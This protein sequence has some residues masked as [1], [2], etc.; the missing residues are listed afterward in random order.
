LTLTLPEGIRIPVR[1]S[2][3]AREGEFLDYMVSID[4]FARRPKMAEEK[5]QALLDLMNQ[6]ALPLAEVGAAQGMA[7][8]IEKIMKLAAGQ[9][10]LPEY[11]AIFRRGLPQQLSLSRAGVGGQGQQR[12]DERM[13]RRLPASPRKEQSMSEEAGVAS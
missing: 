9:F 1:W 12:P 7:L 4:P 13:V 10:G 11:A 2:P 6:F 3:E 5:K 8:D